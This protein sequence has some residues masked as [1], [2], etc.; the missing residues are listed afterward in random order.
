MRATQAKI[1]HDNFLYNIA[2]IRSKISGNTR[3][4]VPVKADAYGH[5]AVSI[6]KTAVQSG[7]SHLAVATIQEGQELRDA[8]ITCSIVLLSPPD[9]TDTN[10]LVEHSLEPFITS[11]EIVDHLAQTAKSAGNRIAVHIKIDTGM[12]SIGCPPDQ[13]SS[14]AAV[15]DS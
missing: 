11:V 13:T 9:V 2:R 5:G 4:C 1:H 14:L 3:I 15:I 12:G 7:V 8:G 10:L 6:A